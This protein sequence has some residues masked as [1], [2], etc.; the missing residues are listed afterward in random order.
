MSDIADKHCAG[1]T[2]NHPPN[3]AETRWA[4][5]L[6]QISWCNEVNDALGYY[7]KN[8]AT[9]VAT[10]DDQT[11]Y[12][13]WAFDDD[14][15]IDLA[16]VDAVLRPV[17]GF[18]STLEA[19]KQ[20]TSSMALPMELMII[21]ATSSEVPVDVFHYENGQLT[22]SSKDGDL[23]SDV[24]QAVRRA[25]HIANKRRF[26]DKERIGHLEDMLICT[27]L[28]PRFKLMNFLGCTAQMKTDAEEYLLENYKADWSPRAVARAERVAEKAAAAVLAAAMGSN[29]PE[30][31]EDAS[32]SDS[33]EPESM[34]VGDPESEVQEVEVAPIFKTKKD[35]KKVAKGG[36]ANFMSNF[37][38]KAPSVAEQVPSASGD[39]EEVHRYLRLP[40]IPLQ[41]ST[42]EDQNILLWWKD[43]APSFPHLS[44]M[45]RQFLAAPA[46][47]ASAERL[48]SGAGKMHDDLKKATTEGTLE[49]QLS[50]ATNYP[51]A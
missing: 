18:I 13:D 28:D 50:V 23:L 10:N 42:G 14:D 2:I 27:I 40:Q 49:M 11:T 37:A 5:L 51:D 12:V 3:G 36:L 38:Q 20:V 45:A 43:H 1:M 24:A 15:R 26:I 9:N 33:D 46:S 32:G 17:A 47:S 21:H 22:V 39:Y 30:G 8:P 4:G 44:K 41:T 6:P 7:E 19:G 48:F 35:V 29:A 31:D 25:L 34:Q 16:D